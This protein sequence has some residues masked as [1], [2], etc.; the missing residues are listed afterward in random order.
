VNYVLQ[1]RWVRENDPRFNR[2]NTGDPPPKQ[3][4]R[5]IFLTSEGLDR[6]YKIRDSAGS[7]YGDNITAYLT[8]TQQS[9]IQIGS[10]N[11][12]QSVIFDE[13]DTQTL[14]NI[15]AE[16]EKIVRDKTEE[17]PPE[18]KSQVESDT[19]DLKQELTKSN[20]NKNSIHRKA[21]L[22][23]NKIKNVPPFASIAFQLAALLLG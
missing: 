17:I 23:F 6:H 3:R 4:F 21:T 19:T 12:T 2:I 5:F 8:N 11:S 16:I 14:R 18:I 7:H 10:K 9:P 22:L 20:K 13:G 15:I 1:K